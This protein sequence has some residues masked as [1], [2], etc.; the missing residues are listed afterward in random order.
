VCC[1]GLNSSFFFRGWG[2]AFP[3]IGQGGGE[4]HARRH[5]QSEEGEIWPRRRRGEESQG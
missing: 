2:L 3:F 5:A 1:V 4:L